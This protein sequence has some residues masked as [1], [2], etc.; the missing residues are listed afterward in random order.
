MNKLRRF[1]RWWRK[2]FPN[3][4]ASEAA[5]GLALVVA[6]YGIPIWCLILWLLGH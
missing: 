4:P 5:C 2:G 1:W 3:Q 6:V